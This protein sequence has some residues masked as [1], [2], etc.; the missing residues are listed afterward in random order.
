[1][2]K[3]ITAGNWKMGKT[4]SET[5]EFAEA[6]KNKVPSND[7]VDSVIRSSALFL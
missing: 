7:E 4:A 3:P 2:R 1:M 5:K 6:V